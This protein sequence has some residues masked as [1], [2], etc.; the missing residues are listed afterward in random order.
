M[1]ASGERLEARVATA[2]VIGK[3]GQGKT[4]SNSRG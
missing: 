1:R 4:A 3:A 2:M